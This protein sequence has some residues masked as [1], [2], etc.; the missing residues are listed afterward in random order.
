MRKKLSIILAILLYFTLTSCS[1]P[2]WLSGLPWG[3]SDPIKYDK[4]EI[5][6]SKYGDSNSLQNIDK[7][8]IVG[9]TEEGEFSLPGLTQNKMVLVRVKFVVSN[10]GDEAYVFKPY[11]TI[12]RSKGYQLARYSEDAD[13]STKN[14]GTKDEYIEVSG[15]S[16]TIEVGTLKHS[17]PY[18]FTYVCRQTPDLN[19]I[20]QDWDFYDQSNNNKKIHNTV[21][22]LNFPTNYDTIPEPD[23]VYNDNSIDII[24]D[25]P[26]VKYCNYYFG[27]KLHS[28]S[29]VDGKYTIP[30]EKSGDY[31]IKLRSDDILTED[32]DK[33]IYLKVLDDVSNAKFTNDKL[34]SF[35]PVNDANKY[36]IV[37]L[38][39]NDNEMDSF[40]ITDTKIN[41]KEKIAAYSGG[42]Y[43]VKIYSNSTENRIFKSLNGIKM[44]FIVLNSPEVTIKNK[45]ISWSAV[46]GA[47]KYKIYKKNEFLT[48][49][50]ELKYFDS[51]FM[52]G[53]ELYVVAASESLNQF[54]SLKSNKVKVSVI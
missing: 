22:A 37:I 25:D 39:S 53:D 11:F 54:D 33:K 51:D 50:T 24:S 3:S 1:G 43:K 7:N 35:D 5:T 44:D 46:S 14:Q 20:Y 10:L 49:T 15:I 6:I 36:D 21:V 18:V 17:I 41:I 42:V 47:T 9:P 34:V 4:V 52:Y 26:K 40:S 28:I 29:K 8:Q 13:I 2:Q 45:E 12:S 38:D 30:V 16:K 27:E 23:Y 19:M 32:Y 48:E 31:E